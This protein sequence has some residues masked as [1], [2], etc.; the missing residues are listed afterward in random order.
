[1]R[2]M[3]QE[4]LASRWFMGTE[5]AARTLNATTQEGMRF[6]QGPLERHLKTNQAHMRLPTLNTRM[7]SDSLFG[8]VKSVRGFT[9]AQLFTYGHGFS[10]VYPMK[11]KADAHHALMHFIH[12]VGAPKDLLTDGAQEEMRG[13]WGCIVKQY[14][15]HQRT[16]EP[17]SSWQNRA[18]PKIH[19]LKNLTCR[20]LRSSNFPNLYWCYALEWASRV[21]SHTALDITFLKS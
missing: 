10:R 14:H 2:R 3:C 1:M 4:E 9:C 19:E 13:E 12:E 20:A 8:N 5:T 15:I 16:T 18:E 17:K 7:Y 21:R 11:S 6:V